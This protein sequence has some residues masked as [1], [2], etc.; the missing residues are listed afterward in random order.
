VLY[1]LTPAHLP[2]PRRPAVMEYVTG[3]N[4]GL[5]V[6]AFELDLDEGLVAFRAGWRSRR[7]RR[8]P[9]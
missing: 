9:P 3:A 6:G 4:V 1:V 2:E 7:A 8:F 5:R